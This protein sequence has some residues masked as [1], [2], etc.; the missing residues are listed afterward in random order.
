VTQYA[1]AGAIRTERRRRRHEEQAAMQRS[2]TQALS[3]DQWR[4]LSPVL[5]EMVTRLGS[6]D[7]QG[8][9]LRFY[10]QRSF[11]DVG[12]AMGVSE[13]A[14]RKRVERAVQKLRSL[15]G[16]RG[17][18]SSST[19][20][21]AAG[22]L[23]HATQP[24]PAAM[25]PLV[26][27]VISSGASISAS[28][29]SAAKAAVAV[30]TYAKAKM[31]A[32]A[33]LGILLIPITVVVISQVRASAP[34]P[35]A[36]APA[37]RPATAP[38]VSRGVDVAVTDADGNAVV[39]AQIYAAQ[40]IHRTELD[41]EHAQVSH[42]GPALSDP[43][44]HAHLS[45]LAPLGTQYAWQ[46][47]FYVRHPQA[48]V[49]VVVRSLFP[50]SKPLSAAEPVQ[51]RLNRRGV[52]KGHLAMPAGADPRT[53]RVWVELLDFGDGPGR[54][55]TVWRQMLNPFTTAWPELFNATPNAAGEFALE[56]LPSNCSIIAIAAAPGLGH[57]QARLSGAAG[58]AA[59]PVTMKLQPQGVISG[60]IT[61]TGSSKPAPGVRMEVFQRTGE[62]YNEEF[63]ATTDA[64][65]H[66]RVEGLPEGIFSLRS[67]LETAEG[68][69][70]VS[71]EDVRVDA[72]QIVDDLNFK[73]EQ[74]VLAG[75]RVVIQGTSKPAVGVRI[76]GAGVLSSRSD[77]DGRFTIRLAHGA[78]QLRVRNDA[79]YE[80]P[81][82]TEAQEVIVAADDKIQG[83]L[84]FTVVPNPLKPK[85][86]ATL[87]GQVMDAAGAAV[88]G[89]KIGDSR[90]EQW[91][92]GTMETADYAAGMTDAQG[93]FEFPIEAEIPHELSITSPSYSGRSQKFTPRPGETLEVKL[94]A[95]ARPVLAT[96]HGTVVDLD[97]NP[98]E[99][100]EVNVGSADDL[101]T[102]AQGQFRA[103]IR[104][105]GPTHVFLAHRLYETREYGD[106]IPSVQELT[107]TLYRR[108]SA[109]PSAH[110]QPMPDSKAL[111][112]KP[113]PELQIASWIHLP[114][115][116]KA[117]E[118]G[119]GRKTLVMFTFMFD[120]THR[121]P[122]K[123]EDWTNKLQDAAKRM[124][125]DPIIIF[126]PLTHDSGVKK[127][128]IDNK[129][130]AAVALD[131]YVPECPY[132]FNGLTRI[133]FGGQ[134]FMTRVFLVDQD[135]TVLSDDFDL[136]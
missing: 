123:I 135:G 39:G 24:A 26:A 97:N 13:D 131:Q 114:D 87:K 6:R 66:Y 58:D 85:T 64:A 133:S 104:S 11:A 119:K 44:G 116:N 5:E 99:G 109:N 78:N 120:N 21:L 27:G 80:S 118:I 18:T 43:Q 134:R 73:L 30:M 31:V 19:S 59:Q 1:A 79:A 8:I 62:N 84:T 130:T 41:Y 23:I 60:A 107:F 25:A 128:V 132:M 82:H 28:A 47:V 101:K 63:I 88:A 50:G 3:D 51:I 117:P 77:A 126:A 14:A 102:N 17:I 75:G 127:F 129:V 111:I 65:G 91:G 40:L 53:A 34:P 83:D 68:Y 29:A 125:A 90:V 76:G 12:A 121:Y 113:A 124:D 122:G 45:D 108:T 32:A 54:Q 115:S 71:Q 95:T 36:A 33:L 37:S 38:V 61:Y 22:L 52:F 81:P 9:I 69:V 56:D 100:V 72:G 20:L 4:D 67:N 46:Q 49:A 2:E 10:Q 15:L 42:A 74:G 70:G 94:S 93:R 110:N 103:E 136:K 7:R 35:R 57:A 112:G 106:V 16:A 96:L 86:W 55:G 92:A 98:I 48:G 105:P 89:V